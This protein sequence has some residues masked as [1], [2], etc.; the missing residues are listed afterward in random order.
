MDLYRANAHGESRW[1]SFE[2]PN[3]EKGQGAKENQG[4]KGHPYDILRPGSSLTLLDVDGPG[5]IHRIW[6]SLD[7]LFDSPQAMRSLRIDMYWDHSDEP[8]V[9][10]PLSEFFCQP[11]ARMATFE[12]ALF[13][14]PEGRSFVCYAPMPFRTGARIAVTNE[15]EGSTHRLFYD[16]NFSRV[17]SLDNDVL[18]F[19]AYWRREC[20][21]TLARDFE[22]LPK[23]AGTG[24]YLGTSIGVIADPNNLGWWGEGEV[25]VYL[26]GDTDHPTLAGTGTEDYI[27]TGWGQGVF[28]NRYQGSLLSDE[29]AGLFG[30]YRL[31]V[32]DP[33]YFQE[34]CRVTIQ[35]Q[36]GTTK[37]EVLQMLAKG[38]AIRPASV[39]TDDSVQHN[40]LEEGAS[41]RL[42]DDTFPPDTWTNYLR[43]DD[44]CAVAYFYLDSPT[45]GLPPLAPLAERIKNMPKSIESNEDK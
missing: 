6:M 13:A 20:P 30:F 11:L 19:H 27:G 28:A 26:D 34:E 40:L 45:N 2:N 35:Q 39:I 24:R 17:K 44:V 8:A 31:H 12:N 21:T 37:K 43:Q 25:K 32:P 10:S 41:V 36:G 7:E 38:V 4:A 18:Y 16:V 3:A 29:K 14:S 23:V 1:A 42:E 33:V 15:S 9:S 5:I 22:I